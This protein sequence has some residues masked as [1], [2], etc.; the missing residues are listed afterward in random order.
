MTT[1][2]QPQSVA[3]L[4]RRAW[5]GYQLRLDEKM[6]RAGF[7][8]RVV[9]DGRVLRMCTGD[10]ASIS[11]IGRALAITRQGAGK[12][13]ASLVE[14]GYVSSR[15]SATSGREKVVTLTE[16]G[17]AYL[18]ALRRS[19]QS[20]DRELRRALGPAP[21]AALERLTAHLAPG[22]TP[23]LSVYLRPFGHAG[24]LRRPEEAP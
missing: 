9:P 15:A 8:D 16:R 3:P 5:V 10:G 18:V 4:L 2:Q 20:I 23:P 7:D 17:R 14:R 6:A 12:M 19:R 24:A 21:L 13:V 22:D 11:Q 1:G